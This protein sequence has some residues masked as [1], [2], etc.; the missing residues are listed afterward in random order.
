MKKIQKT[1]NKDSLSWFLASIIGDNAP[2]AVQSLM[3]FNIVE[4]SQL[5]GLAQRYVPKL[6]PK[7]AKSRGV[8][9]SYLKVQNQPNV[10]RII[11]EFQKA[12][13]I[14][15]NDATKIFNAC[16][17]HKTALQRYNFGAGWAFGSVRTK[18]QDVSGRKTFRLA[19]R[20]KAKD[21]FYLVP[22][23]EE[24][25]PIFDQGERGTCVANSI[26]TVLNYNTGSAWSRQ[27]LHHQ[28]K[29]VDGVPNEEGTYIETAADVLCEGKFQDLGNVRE[30]IWPYNP[31]TQKSLHQGPPPE[32]SYS[33]ERIFTSDQA[34]YVR[35]SSIIDDI[36]YLLNAVEN[37][38]AGLV[39]IGVAIY[40]S[41]FSYNTA[42]TGWV[43]MPLPGEA[44]VG[45]HAMTICGYDN[46]RGLFLVRNSWGPHWAHNN[47]KGFNGHAW[48]PYKYIENNCHA[49]V[50][51]K[52]FK[53]EYMVIPEEERLNYSIAIQ[54]YAG[55][56]AAKR[57][58]GKVIRMR[59]GRISLG[60]WIIRI[61]AVWLLWHAYKVPILKA[62]ENIRIKIEENF[63]TT[64]VK[65]FITELKEK[66]N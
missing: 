52:G 18:K 49:A 40:E 46:E 2:K 66:I 41:F 6:S 22:N 28:S 21:G 53:E 45:Y 32:R 25:G 19:S 13:Q 50:S 58:K 63:D 26:C 61:A 12:M 14:S 57:S 38:R 54:D 62:T 3:Q 47:D 17:K 33:T 5:I 35:E 7:T 8:A 9:K 16:R 31:N 65:N 56:A 15:R 55:R 29:M 34:I 4:K 23:Y 42:D 1:Q 30:T 51:F 27:F 43:T 10:D 11:S 39:V 37:G 59:S 60:G 64:D 20:H 48:I 44:I 24:T 36:K